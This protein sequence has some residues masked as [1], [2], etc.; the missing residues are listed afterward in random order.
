MSEV[1]SVAVHESIDLSSLTM[2]FITRNRQEL[3]LKNSRIYQRLG[4]SIVIL[5]GSDSPLEEINQ[6]S[7]TDRFTYIYSFECLERRLSLAAKCV[8]TPFTIVST[9]DDLLVPSALQKSINFLLKHP[10]ILSCSGRAIGFERLS[11]KLNLLDCYPEHDNPE[12]SLLPSSVILRTF[13]YFRTYSSRYFYSVYRTEDWISIYTNFVG[14]KPLPRN[15]LELIIEFRACLKGSH[16]IL[17]SLFWLR[18]FTNAPIRAEEKYRIF[19]KPTDYIAVFRETFSTEG[20]KKGVSFLDSV[21]K[22]L[23]ISLIILA[24]DVKGFLVA[25]RNK[26]RD[27]TALRSNRMTKVEE[28]FELKVLLEAKS[29]ACSETEIRELL[30]LV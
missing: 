11:S 26:L 1:Q 18:N 17:P 25:L 13:L 10:E 6:S 7:F 8:Q 19:A 9:D 4:A 22:S 3:V 30:R 29:T 20:K 21:F 27:L 15:Y 5:D 12:I 2:V 14:E 28:K 24:L 16:H 23:L